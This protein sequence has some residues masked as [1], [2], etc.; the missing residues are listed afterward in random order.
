MDEK[1]LGW[2]VLAEKFSADGDPKSMRTAAREIFELDKDSVEAFAI[3]AEVELYT[4]NTSEAENLARQALSVE[5]NHLRGRL[6]LGGVAV[7]RIK[8]REQLK[9]FDE[10]ITDAQ[11]TLRTLHDKL[12]D[13]NRQFAFNRRQRTADDE[14]FCKHVDKEISVTRAI[15]FK[16]LCWSANGLY[17]AGEPARAAKNLAAA[18]ELTERA[19][20]A[21]ELYSKHLFL[22]NYRD[23]SPAQTLELAQKY[24]SF[25]ERVPTFT[26]DRKNRRA[27]KI[28]VGYISPDFREHALANFMT[29]LLRDFDAEN[30][31]VTCYA[32]GKK[33]FVTDKLKKFPVKWRSLLGKDSLAATC[34]GIRRTVACRFSRTNPRPCKSSRWA[35]RQRRDLP[36]SII[37]CRTKFVCRKICRRPSPKKFCAWSRAVS[38]T[39]RD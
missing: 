21:A 8:L 12:N 24:N 9:I 28:H 17:L 14:E 22:R 34:R 19:D 32:T 20:Q 3:M 36:P 7:K 5:P 37:F 4:G 27:D 1:I 10:V 23:V 39:R 2:V 18:S 26:H 16:A 25:F 31:S 29:P 38:A 30:F 33:D 6:I 15:L 13:Y 11:A 35:T